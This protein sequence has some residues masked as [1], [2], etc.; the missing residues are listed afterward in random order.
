M[1]IKIPTFSLTCEEGGAPSN[2]LVVLRV[3]YNQK[4]LYGCGS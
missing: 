4:I 2:A 1:K 3:P